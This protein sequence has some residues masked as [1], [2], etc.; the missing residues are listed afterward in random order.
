MFT[1][2][3][4]ASQFGSGWLSSENIWSY[5]IWLYIQQPNTCGF[6]PALT[7]GKEI[8]FQ[9]FWP[10][11]PKSEELSPSEDLPITTTAQSSRAH[12]PQQTTRWHTLAC[13]CSTFWNCDVSDRIPTLRLV[14]FF[15]HMLITQQRDLE[16]RVREWI[17]NNNA[18]V[19]A[20][21]RS[22]RLQ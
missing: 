16:S 11:E 17:I 15:L 10:V 20:S 18:N 8:D 19:F 7:K 4:A 2:V 21:I 1:V 14:L 22:A 6:H 5:L 12:L 13:S 3:Q 9:A